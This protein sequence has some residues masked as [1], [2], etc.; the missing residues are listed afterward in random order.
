MRVRVSIFTILAFSSFLLLFTLFYI[1]FLRI[2]SLGLSFQGLL[3]VLR[4]SY[5]RRVI[6][7]TFGQAVLSTVLTLIVSFPGAYV[8]SHYDF[9]GKRTLKAII[10]VPF[11]MPSVMVALGFIILFGKQGPF[12]WLNIL[13]SWK[14]IVLAHIFYNYPVVV[15][16]VSSAWERINPHYEEA[17]LSLGAKGFTLFRKVT[18]PLLFPS[19]LLSSLMTFIFC[20]M[21]FSIPLILGGYK[22]ATIE[23]AI[24]SSAMML[25]DFKTSSSLALLQLVF[26][27]LLM[28][29][30]IKIASAYS[31]EEEQKVNVRRKKLT[32]SPGG[33]LILSYFILIF[34]LILGPL[35]AV[36]LDSFM[37]NGKFS[38]EWYRRAFSQEYNPMFGTS[39]LFAL[40]NTLRFGFLAVGISLL[41]SLPLAYLSIRKKLR[42]KSI[43]DV[44]VTLPLA[45]S[46]VILGLGYLITFRSSPIYGHWILIA[47]AHATVAYPFVFRTVSLAIQKVKK[48]LSEAALTLGAN[49]AYSFM[50]IELPLIKGG[51][52][53]AS[54]FAFAISVAEL[55]TTYMLAKPEYTTLTLAI[56]KFISSRQFG[57]ASA[58]SVILMAISMLSFLLIE[59]I[60]EE[61]W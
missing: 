47:L 43:I 15:R 50:R 46:P 27:F 51:V 20:F 9:P 59:R 16:I 8:L 39:S 24:F 42:G 33:I 6:S 34:L 26:N 1:P 44:L 5:Y 32:L 7:F 38:F 3:A 40:L 29:L 10:T 37:F 21:S 41:L 54:V 13:Y 60:G 49:E 48:N 22:Y 23:V 25:L 19:I 4:D 28:Y 11:V 35:F 17:A 12:S 57:P 45:S 61:V 53:V 18:L 30:Y 36:F 58:L 56:Y 31:R 14:A 55:A 52:L 2:L